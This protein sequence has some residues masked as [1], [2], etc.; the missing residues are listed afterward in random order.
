MS[1]NMSFSEP[2]PLL[3]SGEYYK[4]SELL[5][6]NTNYF[7]YPRGSALFKLLYMASRVRVPNSRV[8]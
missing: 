6:L 3:S 7:D 2:W 5:I 8:P 1:W 4:K